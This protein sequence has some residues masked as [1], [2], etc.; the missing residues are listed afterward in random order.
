MLR[1]ACLIVLLAVSTA[2]SAQSNKFRPAAGGDDGRA[3]HG[4]AHRF[5]RD[6]LPANRDEPPDQFKMLACL[7][8]HRAKLS[9]PCAEMLQKNGV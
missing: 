3:C 9:R 6:L 1:C 2:A 4:D 8:D 7:Q 5:C